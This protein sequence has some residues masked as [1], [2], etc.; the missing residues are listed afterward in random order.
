MT[1]TAS[2]PLPDRIKA[3]RYLTSEEA[4]WSKWRGLRF[5]KLVS[6]ATE[7]GCGTG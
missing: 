6:P 4:V 7:Q 5:N 1:I 2:H 3:D